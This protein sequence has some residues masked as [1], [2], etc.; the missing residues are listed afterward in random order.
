MDSN[1]VIT[2]VVVSVRVQGELGVAQRTAVLAS[3]VGAAH[4][5]SRVELGETYRTVR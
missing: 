5:A 2:R 4:G 3:S 1:K